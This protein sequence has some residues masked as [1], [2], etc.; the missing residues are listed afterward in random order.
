MRRVDPGG[1]GPDLVEMIGDWIARADPSAP[2]PLLGIAGS[3]GS[4]KSTLAGA[5]AERFDC[6]AL[7]LDDV[8]L[9]RA[10]R[11]ALAARV[12]P[13]FA[14]RGPP[15]THD[16]NLLNAVIDRLRRAGPG[17][18][19]P[20]PRFDKLADDR[21]PPIDWPVFRGR[22]RAVVIEGWCLGA[23]PQDARAL[24]NPVND[25]ERVRDPGGVWRRAVNARLAGDYAETFAR[26]D[27]LVF[28]RAPAFERVLDWR[29][30][31]ETGLL[32]VQR[33]TPERRAALGDFIQ[34][35]ER[36][37]RHMLAGGVGADLTVALD[38]QRRPLGAVGRLA[39]F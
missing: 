25:L 12:H 28:L 34:H 13:L 37:T 14:V 32:G 27:T 6:A 30:E 39:R 7:S 4:G 1:G 3:Q 5:I 29:A 33:L 23:M 8:Y 21:A 10:E 38:D 15:G 2:P 19:T 11:R 20:L 16:L 17:D 26:M 22:P 24:A 36:L 31:Q 18:G 9:T 35:Y